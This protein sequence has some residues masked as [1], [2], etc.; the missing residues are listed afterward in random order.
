VVGEGVD[1]QLVEFERS[2]AEVKGQRDDGLVAGV[3]TRLDHGDDLVVPR[4]EFSRSGAGS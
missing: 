4:D 2:R 3:V 1:R